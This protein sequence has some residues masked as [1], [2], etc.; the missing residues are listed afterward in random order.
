LINR[1]G[2]NL[3]TGER[4]AAAATRSPGLQ[5]GDRSRSPGACCVQ[6]SR[7]AAL[8]R[9]PLAGSPHGAAWLRLMEELTPGS[10]LAGRPNNG[11][12]QVVE[13]WCGWPAPARPGVTSRPSTAPGRRWPAA[14]TAGVATDLQ[15]AAGRG[16][17]PRRYLRELN[18]LVHY[19]D[20]SVVRAHQDASGA[21][22]V[23]AVE[24]RKRGSRTRQLSIGSTPRWVEH[25][26][27][28]AQRRARAA[29]GPAGH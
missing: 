17:P 21:R 24:D 6:D 3:E 11:H 9:Y 4:T 1:L 13:R 12:R 7:R 28:P 16:P 25:Q 18:W 15:A 5:R 29:A 27:V 8:P 10:C 26:A 20:G 14:S 2:P 19:L 23:P 22:H